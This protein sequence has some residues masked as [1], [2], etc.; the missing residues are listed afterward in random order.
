MAIS[1]NL[2]KPG[3]DR[4]IDEQT[5]AELALALTQ[6]IG[7]ERKKSVSQTSRAGTR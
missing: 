1:S 5:R 3:N 6:T 4:V 2:E 7:F